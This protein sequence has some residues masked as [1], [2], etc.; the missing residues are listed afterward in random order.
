MTD[1]MVAI[2]TLGRVRVEQEIAL[3]SHTWPNGI[4]RQLST[5]KGFSTCDARN[6]HVQIA[7][8][9]G[10]K[11]L[12]FWDDDIAPR[13]QSAV[14]L[15]VSAMEQIEDIDILGGVYPR[16]LKDFPEPI[17]VR[18]GKTWWGWEDGGIHPVQ[19][20]GTGFTLIRVAALDKIQVPTYDIELEDKTSKTVGKYF[21][22]R[23]GKNQITDDFYLGDLCSEFGVRWFVAGQIICDQYGDDGH[24]YSVED[25]KVGI[26]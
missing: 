3:L 12:M 5:I 7:K 16:R 11:Y 24:V 1:L 21:A 2:C 4:S 6:L 14:S 9:E 8:D 26:A 23:L 17:V 10:V 25:A 15:M 20:T 13:S 19:I 18:E 22:E